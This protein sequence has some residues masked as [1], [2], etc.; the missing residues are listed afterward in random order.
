MLR[1]DSFRSW[2]EDEPNDIGVGQRFLEVGGK[3][4]IVRVAALIRPRSGIPHARLRQVD[5]ATKVVLVSCDALRDRCA[6]TPLAGNRD[7][8]AAMPARTDGEGERDAPGRQ[9]VGRPFPPPR[10]YGPL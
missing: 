10:W 2:I 6:F 4:R 7:R 1:Y 5:D 8:F 9:P 3:Q